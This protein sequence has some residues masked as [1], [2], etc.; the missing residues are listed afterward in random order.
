VRRGHPRGPPPRRAAGRRAPNPR[1]SPGGPGG[2]TGRVRPRASRGGRRRAPGPRPQLPPTRVRGPPPTR[3]RVLPFSPRL[4]LDTRGTGRRLLFLSRLQERSS[5]HRTEGRRAGSGVARHSTASG[6]IVDRSRPR[7][8]DGYPGRRRGDWRCR[9]PSQT[10][11]QLP[12][13]RRGACRACGH[14]A[15]RDP[16]RPRPSARRDRLRRRLR[17]SELAGGTSL[18]LRGAMRSGS[19]RAAAIGLAR[20]P[21]PV[22]RRPACDPHVGMTA[23]NP[24]S[25]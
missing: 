5:R 20:R 19:W 23:R 21:R 4:S 9:L 1:R 17:I 13:R 6:C 25:S 3:F 12:R 7:L 14:R 8:C 22:R 16:S 15:A 24:R 10:G 18:K 2:G 11:E